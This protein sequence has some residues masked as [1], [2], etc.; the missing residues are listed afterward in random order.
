MKYYIDFETLVFNGFRAGTPAVALGVYCAKTDTS[1]II[2]D[3]G[4]AIWDWICERL[5]SGDMLIGWNMSFDMLIAATSLSGGDPSVILEGYNNGQIVCMMKADKLLAIQ[6]GTY[7]RRSFDLAGACRSW[8]NIAIEGKGAEHSVVSATK[9]VKKVEKMR[10]LRRMGAWAAN[11]VRGELAPPPAEIPLMEVPWRYKYVLLRQL[12]LELWPLEA[13]RYLGRDCTYLAE[14][15][16]HI[17]SA[18]AVNGYTESGGLT[19]HTVFES[20][21]SFGL[22]LTENVG[23]FVRTDYVRDMQRQAQTL[24]EELEPVLLS[25]GVLKVRTTGPQKGTVGAD[26]KALRQM[27]SAGYLQVGLKPLRTEAS[28]TFPE[29][30]VQINDKVLAETPGR[31]PEVY[32]A[33]YKAQR[34]VEIFCP[35]LL[36]PGLRTTYMDAITMRIT[37]RSG[38]D[39]IDGAEF[40]ATNQPRTGG[41]R[42]AF[43]PPTPEEYAEIAKRLKLPPVELQAG[44]RWIIVSADYAAAE[45]YTGAINILWRKTGVAEYTPGISP[46]ADD[47]MNDIDIPSM[48]A[49]IEMGV[50]YEH[51]VA[52]RKKDPS[53]KDA[54]QR[55]KNVF[56]GLLGMMGPRKNATQAFKAGIKFATHANGMW[57]VAGSIEVAKATMAIALERY[58][59]ID[60]HRKQFDFNRRH[61]AI[62]APSGLERGDCFA[63][64]AGNWVIQPGVARMMKRAIF[65]MWR[66]IYTDLGYTGAL[67]FNDNHDECLMY[68]LERYAHEVGEALREEMLASKAI[69]CPGMVKRHHA[70]PVA[71]EVWEKDVEPTYRDGRL[72]VTPCSM[73]TPPTYTHPWDAVEFDCDE[74]SIDSR[75]AAWLREEENVPQVEDSDEQE[76]YEYEF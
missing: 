48:I 5:S 75:V 43:R 9:G 41:I 76:D 65:N 45:C 40:N 64:E 1:D 3:V 34:N 8:L 53:F 42:Q 17:C 31:L 2:L 39:D 73:Q 36:T 21:S 11:L 63:T 44:D 47:L 46:L 28:S 26:Q 56:Y 68:C 52:R 69:E 71:T 19:A 74:D 20:Q 58:W 66:R 4:T 18:A 61:Q 49:S 23:F 59:D 60:E 22:V 55:A 32:R 12:P 6:N 38:E 13:Q 33:W 54:R 10:W 14:L 57:D 25:A 16:A 7:R 72:V 37:S 62:T 30:Q 50:S 27:V 51:F 70:V 67:V 29:G 15:A 35:L 24:K